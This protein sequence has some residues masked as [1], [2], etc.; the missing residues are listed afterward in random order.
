MSCPWCK[1]FVFEKWRAND[2]DEKEERD[3]SKFLELEKSIYL[4]A[5]PHNGGVFDED[6]EDEGLNDVEDGEIE[7]IIMSDSDDSESDNDG[8]DCW[9]TA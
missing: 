3:D 5:F 8:E 6:E 7:E 4:K 9:K 1:G 2:W